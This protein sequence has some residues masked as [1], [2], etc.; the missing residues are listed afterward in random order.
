MKRTICLVTNWYPTKEN[1]YAGLFFKDQA[2]A[3]SDFYDFLIIHYK[4]KLK[5][6]PG[7]RYIV[8]KVNEERNTV[9]YDVQVRVPV[10]V[11]I[12][13]IITDFKIKHIDKNTID[14]IGKYVSTSRVK[15]TNA[16]IGRLFKKYFEDAFDVL[17]CVD[18]QN[19][20]FYLQ[21]ISDFSGKPYVVGEHAPIPWPGSQIKD[22][23]K[24]AIEKSNL[25]L[26]ISNDKIRQV[27][28]QNIN[29]PKVVYLGNLVDET[30]FIIKKKSP[31]HIKT[32]LIVAAYSFYKN[33]DLF[34]KVIERLTEITDEDFRVMIVGYA[35]NKGYSKNANQLEEKIRKSKFANKAELVLEVPHE[36]MGEI[37]N[38][39]DVFVMTSIQEGQPVSAL[40]AACCGLPIFSTRCGGVEDYVDDEIGRIYNVIDYEEM[41]CGLRDYLEG[42]IT[43]DSE[44][45]RKRT[46][47]LFGINA[48]T[49]K[50]KEAFDGVIE[51]D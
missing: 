5:K 3:V 38:A 24:Y 39:A 2:F 37:Y 27:L 47:D 12:H 51:N 33:Y 36:K 9:E 17:Y 8:T 45:I 10:W 29:L 43:F 23:N 30:K 35:S 26:A 19:E 28:L 11:Y 6:K 18:A 7:K 13:D 20:A 14:G 44:L 31:N 49:K 34:I 16:V 46:V 40:E 41:A 42:D 1:P 25:F 4:E 48:F 15:F 32:L 21:C 50:F 22:V